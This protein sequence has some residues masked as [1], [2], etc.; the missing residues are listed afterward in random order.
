MPAR[1]SEHVSVFAVWRQF[2]LWFLLVG[3]AFAGVVA[4]IYWQDVRHQRF[5][6]EQEAG[7]VLELQQELLLFELQSVQSDLLYLADQELL[8]SFLSGD[9]SL[10]ESLERNYV[11][12]AV[13]KAVYDQVRC[14][15]MAG[16]EI[17]RINY[18]DGNAEVVPQEELQ[19]KA[20]RYYYQRALSLEKG[21][22]Y[23]T[24]FDL[25]VEH[26]EI[27][28]PIRPVIRFITP[29]VDDTGKKR[30]LLVLNYVGKHLLSKMQQASSG[31]RGETM[32]LN[33]EGE[34]LQAPDPNREWG[35]LL[36]HPRSFRNDF[37]SAWEQIKL[38]D[39]GHVPHGRRLFTFRRIS[40]ESATSTDKG[41]T[42]NV[43]LDQSNSL[44]LISYV[45][46]AVATAHSKALLSRLLVMY[47]GV[48]AVVLVLALHRAR[49]L[50]IHKRQERQIEESEVRL[51][52]LSRM[53]L[54]AQEN[55]RRNLSHDLHDE[56]GQQVTAIRLDL[57]SLAQENGGSSPNP[58]LRRT[59]EATDELLKS[60]H[61]IATRVRP[62]VLDDLGLQDAAQSFIAEY[63][64]RTGI[65]VESE[66]RL[67]KSC[68]PPVVGENVYRILQESLAN[69]AAHARADAVEVAMESNHVELR[70]TVRD[71]GAG[72][73]L[74]ALAD[75][76]R[77]GILGMR[78][79]AE[80]LN[81]QFDLDSTPGDGTRVRVVIPLGEYHQSA[82][83]IGRNTK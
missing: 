76:T 44:I 50:A 61:E 56:L 75:S 24:P 16:H 53:L 67:D 66:L 1:P 40:P 59:I 55:E 11:S 82:P 58:L 6:L 83:H 8:Q 30:G 81:G 39:V 80:L 51:R 77:L 74:T 57:K 48:M 34:Y 19:P 46:S 60:V 25:N 4:V 23:I 69:V 45:S 38:F 70:M 73:D 32:L 13:N 29:V 27:Q 54:T 33:S 9:D 26:G 36:D 18:H 47:L 22:V 3:L 65:R 15:A 63:Q 21:E 35:W 62:S 14:L 20:T 49:S 41:I 43:G 28:R 17:I 2:V 72:F 64:H 37:P 79:R 71:R 5:M 52:K 10:R 12:L 31:F 78:E 68:I 7:H 42:P